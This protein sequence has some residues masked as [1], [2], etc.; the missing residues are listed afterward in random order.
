MK[1]FSSEFV[2]FSC[3]SSLNLELKILTLKG[4]GEVLQSSVRFSSIIF[5]SEDFSEQKVKGDQP[6]KA[7]LYFSANISAIR[8]ELETK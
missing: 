7:N 4:N 5:S 1:S 8:I 2:P 3:A 6:R